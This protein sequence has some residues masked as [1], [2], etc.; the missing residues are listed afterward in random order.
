MFFATN[1]LIFA[2]VLWVTSLSMLLHTMPGH[3]CGCA[4]RMR[5]DQ[6]RE[7]N[8]KAYVFQA[9]TCCQ[10]GCQFCQ[11]SSVSLMQQTC[12]HSYRSGQQSNTCRPCSCSRVR[13]ISDVAIRFTKSINDDISLQRQLINSLM[14]SSFLPELSTS[15]YRAYFTA[16][17][18]KPPDSAMC[19][20]CIYFCRLTT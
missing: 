10:L 18:S 11:K 1:R 5:G 19:D 3:A 13:T 7:L 12:C 6:N 9:P 15:K 4:D 20:R 14:I 17:N 2:P 8:L 16:S